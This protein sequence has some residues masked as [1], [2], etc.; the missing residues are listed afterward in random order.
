[1]R[2]FMGGALLS[3]LL[4][5]SSYAHAARTITLTVDASGTG[6]RVVGYGQNGANLVPLIAS[7]VSVVLQGNDDFPNYFVGGRSDASF[8]AYFDD[9]AFY[10]STMTPTQ[11]YYEF[12]GGGSV[13]TNNGSVAGA[14]NADPSCSTLR[15]SSSYPGGYGDSFEG[16]ITRYTIAEGN[17]LGGAELRV[18]ALVPEPST[19]ALMLA[20]FG[21]VGYAMRRRKVGFTAAA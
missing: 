12:S 20:G 10:F 17:T 11:S 7:Q 1:M 16:K 6:F 19:W 2:R 15:Y 18:I 3:A 21:M 9:N 8:Q 5:S 14:Y 4:L 13:C